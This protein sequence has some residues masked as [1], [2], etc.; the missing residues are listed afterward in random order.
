[1]RVPGY[2]LTSSH[3]RVNFVFDNQP[4][5]GIEGE[6]LSAALLANEIRLIGRSFKFH[7]PR[8][9]VSIG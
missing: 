1:M 6:S 8:G 2:G 7:R 9:I 4:L 5:Q 3:P